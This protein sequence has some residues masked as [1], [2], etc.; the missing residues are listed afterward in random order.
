MAKEF[1]PPAKASTLE[2]HA[3]AAD[4]KLPP[5]IRVGTLVLFETEDTIETGW[6]VQ[7]SM[8]AGG[9]TS[10]YLVVPYRYE[11]RGMPIPAKDGHV[12]A[13]EPPIRIDHSQVL[14]TLEPELP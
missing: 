3:K 1:K 8:S 9:Q 11:G 6:I 5:V 14:A 13:Y 10:S 2:K 4:V 12:Y 7:N